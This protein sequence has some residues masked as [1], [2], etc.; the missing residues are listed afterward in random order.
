MLA[1]VGVGNSNNGS[2]ADCWL[3]RRICWLKLGSY[4]ERFFDARKIYAADRYTRKFYALRSWCVFALKYF[5]AYILRQRTR[6]SAYFLSVRRK[7]YAASTNDTAFFMNWVWGGLINSGARTYRLKQCLSN[8]TYNN[9]LRFCLFLQ[10]NEMFR[11][12]TIS[13]NN[14]K[15][16]ASSSSWDFQDQFEC[17]P[18]LICFS[19]SQLKFKEKCESELIAELF[20]CTTYYVDRLNGLFEAKWENATKS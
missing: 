18:P 4:S 1:G 20:V 19:K 9:A 10:S 13:V 11:S 8:E 3:Q 16:E 7:L 15:S 6:T 2:E 17:F 12:W 14:S 5:P